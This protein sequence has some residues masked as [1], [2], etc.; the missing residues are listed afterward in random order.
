MRFRLTSCS[1]FPTVHPRVERAFQ[2]PR[3]ARFE[4]PLSCDV[5]PI[6]AIL[7]ITVQIAQV[8]VLRVDTVLD[9]V[10]LCAVDGDAG[11]QVRL[12][13]AIALQA[14]R[15]DQQRWNF[16]TSCSAVTMTLL[17]TRLAALHLVVHHR[18]HG[19]TFTPRFAA[20]PP[21]HGDFLGR[22]CRY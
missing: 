11:Q 4:L 5:V 18:R 12:L 14:E 10:L 6:P 15:L 22:N 13:P 21:S 16:T 9:D 8:H 1:H 2:V 3:K 7:P 19:K 17:E 20:T